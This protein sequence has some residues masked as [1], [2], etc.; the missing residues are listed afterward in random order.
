VPAQPAEQTLPHQLLDP[1]SHGRPR[2]TG[3]LGELRFRWQGVARP[4]SSLLDG[5]AQLLTKLVMQGDGDTPVKLK[6][7]SWIHRLH[8]HPALPLYG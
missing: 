7:Q 1:L 5:L 4:Q 3:Q 6:P 8:L 2:D